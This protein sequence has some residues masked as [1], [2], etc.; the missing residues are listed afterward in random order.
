MKNLRFLGGSIE[1]NKK[2]LRGKETSRRE[3]CLRGGKGWVKDSQKRRRRAARRDWVGGSSSRPPIVA[4]SASDGRAAVVVISIITTA[5]S[6]TPPRERSTGKTVS[7][8]KDCL[9]MTLKTRRSVQRRHKICDDKY[10]RG[11]YVKTIIW[12]YRQIR[13]REYAF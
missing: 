1:E 13:F 6:A 8:H 2:R 5:V 10:V 7:F 12:Q 3:R 9:S 11:V 4:I